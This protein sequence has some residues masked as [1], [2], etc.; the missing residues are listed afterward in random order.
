MQSIVQRVLDHV[1]R[2]ALNEELTFL[3]EKDAELDAIKDDV[4]E[5]KQ[6]ISFWDRVN[7]F[8]RSEDERALKHQKRALKETKRDHS[9]IIHNIKGLIREAMHHDVYVRMKIY[10]G[11]IANDVGR[12]RI[13]RKHGSNAEANA[14]QFKIKGAEE[15]LKGLDTLD[16]LVTEASGIE[17]GKLDEQALLGL[18]YDEVLRSA[19]FI[20][21]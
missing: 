5:I 2:E 3:R 7:V 1:D 15:V 18:V 11:E 19:G 14:N 6:D 12:L 4:R 17:P 9:V 16:L 10:L 20:T 21:D 13:T 8:T